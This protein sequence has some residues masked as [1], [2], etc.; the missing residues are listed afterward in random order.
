MAECLKWL[1]FE[2]EPNA[3]KDEIASA[4]SLV[5]LHRHRRHRRHRKGCVKPKSPAPA[6]VQL[7][8][9]TDTQGCL[10]LEREA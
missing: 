4:A 10:K 7:I 9:N 3:T 5:A 8:F 6:N 1:G 2:R